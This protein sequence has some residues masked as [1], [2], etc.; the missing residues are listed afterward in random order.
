MPTLKLGTAVSLL[1]H[2]KIAHAITITSATNLTTFLTPYSLSLPI[3]SNKSWR[4]LTPCAH[5]PSNKSN[6]KSTPCY[7]HYNTT[8]N[9]NRSN[10]NSPGFTFRGC[11]SL[12]S[13]NSSSSTRFS[14][15]DSPPLASSPGSGFMSNMGS[16][17][18]IDDVGWYNHDSQDQPLSAS[19]SMQIHN[20]QHQH[21]KFL[22]LPTVLTLGRVAAVPLLVATFYADSWWGRTAT[23]S[24]FIVAAITDWL[25]GYL[26]RK[27]KLGTAFGAFLDPV[28]DKLMVAAALILLC[29][30]PLEVAMSG[31]VPWLFTVPATAIIGREIT[32]SA[33]REWAASRNSILLEAVAVNNLGKWK[34]ATQMISLTILL[35]AR[36]SSLEGPGILVPSGVILLYISAGLSVWSLAVYVSKIW[37]VLLK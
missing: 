3:N 19:P 24:I 20:Q 6:N 17:N 13:R 36:D 2:K 23:T 33:V 15:P 16:E 32:M 25:D 30:R 11:L 5:L 31:E 35:A 18:K 14:R 37:K 7:Y 22:T 29:S 34:T 26:A 4:T 28:A 1:H 12:P 27:M 21:S 9:N 10:K 8:I